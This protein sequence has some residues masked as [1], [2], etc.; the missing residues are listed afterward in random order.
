MEQLMAVL[1]TRE[2]RKNPLR[3]EGSGGAEG[4]GFWVFSAFRMAIVTN[5]MRKGFGQGD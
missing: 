4:W 3:F 1:G 5:E 2:R